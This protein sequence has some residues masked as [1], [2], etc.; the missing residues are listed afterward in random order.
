M[1]RVSSLV[2][3]PWR[4]VSSLKK[5]VSAL[6]AVAIVLVLPACRDSTGVSE[7][8]SALYVLETI[9]GAPLPATAAE[10]GGQQYILLADS[11]AFDLSG[12]V[13][14]TYVVRWI[15]TSPV[16][17]DTTYRQT[18][19]FPY[20]ISRGKLI[21]GS[22]QSCGPLANCVGWEEGSINPHA[23]RVTARIFWPGDPDFLFTRR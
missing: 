12:Q 15:S 4:L 14:R 8:L 16:A 3:L 10:G 1:R 23:A 20:S 2:M 21:I 19:A 11:L 22:Q 17:L 5:A 7:R 6:S 18:S 9:D 13:R